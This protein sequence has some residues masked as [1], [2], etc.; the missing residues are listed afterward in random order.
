M[1]L[2]RPLP[3]LPLPKAAETKQNSGE[4]CVKVCS[5]NSHFYQSHFLN[6]AVSVVPSAQMCPLP[7]SLKLK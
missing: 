5:G 4:S 7:I 2:T 3:Y 6:H 1:S